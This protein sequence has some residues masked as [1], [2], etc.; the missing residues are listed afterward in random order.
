M[1]SIGEG[2]IS[3]D[4]N[5][6]IVL[7]NN[8]AK[9]LTGWSEDTAIGQ[10][11]DKVF[12]II[13]QITNGQIESPFVKVLKDNQIVKLA[14]NTVL[15][16]KNKTEIEIEGS[17]SPI[18]DNYG[19]IQGAVMIFNDVTEKNKIINEIEYLSFHD[20]L[21]GLYN[22]RFFE[23]Q[24]LK[25]DNDKN[26]PLSII[27][28]D[29]NGLKLTNDAFG[30][31]MGDALLK[32]VAEIM[33]S[34]CDKYNIVARTGGDEFTAILQ[35]TDY[36]QADIICNRI[37]DRAAKETLNSI[38]V[39]VAIGCDTK[40]KASQDMDEIVKNAESNMYKTK[41]AASKK[42][43]TKTLELIVETLIKDYKNEKVHIERVRK[44]C[45]QIGL[46]LNMSKEEIKLLDNA[47][48]FHDVGKI[49]IPHQI[50]NIPGALKPDEYELIKRHAEAGYQ[51]LKSVEEYSTIAN[52]VLCHH[53]RWDGN[54]YPRKLVGSNIPKISRIISIADAY[55]AITAG[56]TY[57]KAL[58]KND[59]IEELKN[60]AGTQ[61]DPKIVDVFINKVLNSKNN[62]L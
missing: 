10:P 38:I 35:K 34:E 57:K 11:Y 2:V 37:I 49:V 51:I 30:H 39:S 8:I 47:G 59:A 27:M 19:E 9:N 23:E 15:I 42:M 22:R 28:L 24:L 50:I 17:A 26:L 52:F 46:V 4:K 21:T 62:D 45:H 33:K 32:K 6:N 12:N 61:F 40:I 14:N 43:R 25:L 7:L 36:V 54:G 13:N 18:K 41:I 55:E 60:N 5:Q 20:Y 53:E 58:N 1:Q 56:R 16:K 3:V 29:V 44:I 48:Y 31:E